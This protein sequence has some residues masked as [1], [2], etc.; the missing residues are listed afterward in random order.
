MGR[1]FTHILFGLVGGSWEK[2]TLS[3]ENNRTWP[4]RRS[5][6]VEMTTKP[7]NVSRDT[8][9]YRA[10]FY[11]KVNVV[12]CFY[13]IW[14]PL[15]ATYPRLEIKTKLEIKEKEKQSILV[16]LL[17]CAAFS[18]NVPYSATLSRSYQM[19]RV[20]TYNER[21]LNLLST[22]HPFRR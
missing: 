6:Q 12:V 7:R 18:L 8:E 2:R 11:Y 22:S 19:V 15:S 14:W 10:Y 1:Q 4:T 9:A 13:P 16:C 21:R 20:D 5:V 17:A 3:V